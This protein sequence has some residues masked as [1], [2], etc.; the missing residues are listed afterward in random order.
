MTSLVTH[1]DSHRSCSKKKDCHS[2]SHS[3]NKQTKSSH[4]S[5][6]N[7]VTCILRARLISDV[8]FMQRRCLCSAVGSLWRECFAVSRALLFGRAQRIASVRCRTAAARV[9]QTGFRT[10]AASELAQSKCVFTA[11]VC[12]PASNGLH[13]KVNR[14]EDCL[15]W[16]GEGSSLFPK[17]TD[18][19]SSAAWWRRDTCVGVPGV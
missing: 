1:R 11:C 2:D 9:R 8:M 10:S 13:L 14:S 3:K 15:L 17:H 18:C 16:R 7:Y 6:L 4:K 5:D 12:L 19:H